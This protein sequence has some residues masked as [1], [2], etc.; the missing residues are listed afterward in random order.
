MN[1]NRILTCDNILI[2]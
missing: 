1:W 2:Y